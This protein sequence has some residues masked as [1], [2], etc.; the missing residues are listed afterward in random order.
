M[1]LVLVVFPLIGPAS[2]PELQQ[3]LSGQV[4]G[5]HFKYMSHLSMMDACK[6]TGS[7]APDLLTIAPVV[8]P[9]VQQAWERELAAH[10]DSLFASYIVNGIREGFRV[11]FQRIHSCNSARANMPTPHPNLVSEY[12]QREAALGRMMIVGPDR[13]NQLQR[14]QISPLGLI[15]KKNKPNKWRLIVDLSAPKGASVNDGIDTV[16]S[17][18]SYATVDHLASLVLGLGRGSYLVKADIKEAYRMVPVHPRDRWLLGVKWEGIIY[19]DKV[20][21][22]GL[23]SAPKIFSAIADAAQWIMIKKGLTSLLHYLDDFILVAPSESAA[24]ESKQILLSTWELLGIP[25]E[26]SK[27]EGPATCLTFLGIEIDTVALEMR[28]PADKLGRLKSILAAT[29][30]KKA[31]TKRELQSLVRLLQH[32]T[33]VVKPGRSF[34]RRL[35]ALLALVGA[36]RAPNHFIRLNQPA[37]ADILWWHIFVEN[38]NGVSLLWNQRKESPDVIV[39]SDASG[40]WGCGAFWLPHWFQI[41]WSVRFQHFS[42]QV[43][44]MIPAVVAAAIYGKAWTGKMVEF[45]I[46]NQAVVDILMSGYSREPHLMHLMRLMVFF[47]SS[48][49]FHF[50]ASHIPGVENTLADAISRNNASSFIRQAPVSLLPP[51]TIPA[52]LLELVAEEVSWTSTRW[53]ELF[54]GVLDHCR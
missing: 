12:L 3:H 35:H 40:N 4:L 25:S 11:G 44:E 1:I 37:R 32:A 47:A 31:V 10:P 38:W 39:G 2:D 28:L 27:L 30:G 29:L 45:K 5:Q 22:F 23:R 36:D 17:S 43:K 13:E 7:E 15:P 20:L 24:R 54:Q 42:I 18:I 48:Y 41:P 26:P 21:P 9:L 51:S 16:S 52:P 34:L 53:A 33:K 49:Q 14:L 6:P 8:T 19:V 46:D 50:A